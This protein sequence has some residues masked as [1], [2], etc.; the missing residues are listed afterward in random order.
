MATFTGKINQQWDLVY[1]KDWKGEPGDGE[2]NRDF[3][4]KVNRHFHVISRLGSGRYIDFLSRD[5]LIKTQNGRKTQRWYFHQQS[6]TIRGAT[7]NQSWE[8]KGRNEKGHI[9]HYYSTNSNWYQIFK[10]NSGYFT[11]TMGKVVSVADRKDREA[12]PVHVLNKLGGRHPSQL[13]RVVY[14]DN[15]GD[16]AYTK[17]GK[18]NHTYGFLAN[19]LFYFRSRLPMQRV[20]ECVGA[21]NVTLK[22]WTKGR[23]AQQWKW[24]PISKTIRGNYWTSYVFSMEGGNLRCRTMNSRWF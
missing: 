20:A 7:T 19:E 3:G 9:L 15:L 18:K 6:R 23:K 2:W 24:D 22:K 11:N 1:A 12:Q 21:S 10:Y 16:Q 8:I 13:W 14:V 4:M 17:K 5:L